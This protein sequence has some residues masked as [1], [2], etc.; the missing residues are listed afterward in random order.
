ML[1]EDDRL[2]IDA[3]QRN[4][5]ANFQQIVSLSPLMSDDLQALASNITDA[6]RLADFIASGLGT[7]GTETKQEVLQTLDVRDPV[8][9]T[10]TGLAIV[11]KQV[12]ANGGRAWIDDPPAN[13]PGATVRFTWPKRPAIAR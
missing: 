12:D 4:I 2:E 5:K 8:D 1:K 3:L 9:A 7:I 10:G 6:G 13:A 11:K